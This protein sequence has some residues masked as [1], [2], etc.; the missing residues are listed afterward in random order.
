MEEYGCPA[1][2]VFSR[3]NAFNYFDALGLKTCRVVG[4]PV[5]LRDA[6]WEIVKV[7][8]QAMEADFHAL[9]DS[10]E[11]VWQLP[12]EV[13]CCCDSIFKKRFKR[14]IYK[15]FK[16]EVSVHPPILGAD[17]TASPLSVPSSISLP[18]LLG[19]FVSNQVTDLFKDIHIVH[20]N[21]R[22]RA[23]NIIVST[24][25]KSGK[26]GDWPQNPCE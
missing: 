2:Y 1:L 6:N 7:K 5:V 11:I 17:P 22:R 8:K 14:K 24:M 16:A 20:P 13:E 3:N 18:E 15:T 19:E 23:V 4:G 26:E 9:I 12:G 10:L 25:P 21:E